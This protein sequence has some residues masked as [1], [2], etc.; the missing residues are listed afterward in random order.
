[1]TSTLDIALAY[2]A[3]TGLPVFPCLPSKKPACPRGFHAATSDPEGIRALWQ[4]HPGPLIGLPTGAASGLSVLDIDAT[5]HPEAAAWFEQNRA[6]L[7]PTRTI[8]SRSG[9][10]H[11]YFRD[12]SSIRCTSAL[13]G[14]PGVD[15]RARGGYILL[16]HL[17]GTRTLSSAP[18]AP[19]PTWLR[20][21][22]P[23]RSERPEAPPQFATDAAIE[24]IIR[25]IANATEGERNRM[26]YWGACR[27]GEMAGLPQQHIVAI[28]RAAADRIGYPGNEAERTA[29]SAIRKVRS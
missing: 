20:P 27:L 17:R 12:D 21:P 26:L 10:W 19:W 7:M 1:M 9:G 5:K 25:F 16:W 15:I 3:E 24:R 14:V 13:F 6:R 29:L 2:A 18:P 4:A 28:I 22:R 8:E 23:A 11:C